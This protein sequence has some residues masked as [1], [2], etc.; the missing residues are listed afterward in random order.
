M[1]M[2]HFVLVGIF[3]GN[4]TSLFSVW[5]FGLFV[6]WLVDWLAFKWKEQ[7]IDISEVRSYECLD[8]VGSFVNDEWEV[9][10]IIEKGE[11][12][13]RHRCFQDCEIEKYISSVRLGM[14][15]ITLEYMSSTL[16]LLRI[17]HTVS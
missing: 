1:G 12:R 6:G 7:K 8:I 17:R 15:L 9:H 5:F 16:Q 14:I 2:V 13:P 10:V 4:A 3:L 11:R